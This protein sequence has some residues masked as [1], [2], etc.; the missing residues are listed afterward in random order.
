MKGGREWEQ[1]E[2][3]GRGKSRR[4]D[5][6]KMAAPGGPYA[7]RFESATLGRCLQMLNGSVS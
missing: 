3:E 7:R 1:E 2:G 6:G 4:T 5:E